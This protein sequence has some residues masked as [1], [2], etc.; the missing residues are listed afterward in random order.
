MLRTLQDKFIDK[1]I[2]ELIGFGVLREDMTIGKRDIVLSWIIQ[3]HK[4]ELAKYVRDIK[5]RQEA[6]KSFVVSVSPREVFSQST[7]TDEEDYNE[8][9]A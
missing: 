6:E 3:E 5:K 1:D 4:T 7:P 8:K 9:D 2:K